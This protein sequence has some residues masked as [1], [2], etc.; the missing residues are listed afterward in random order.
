MSVSAELSGIPKG[1]MPTPPP[2]WVIRAVLAVRRFVVW[3]ADR[4][5]PPDVVVLE[6]AAGVA[7][8]A[9]IATLAKLGYAELLA[10]GPLG[11]REIAARTGCDPDA[12]LRFCHFF[13]TIGW[14][15]MTPDGV[16]S[17]TPFLRALRADN[18]MRVRSFVEYF[19]SR[20]NVD[21]IL[22]IA[23]TLRTG[24]NAFE[25][26]HGAVVWDYFDAHPDE[27]ETFAHA[28]MGLTLAD[29]PFVAKGYPFS[30]VRTVCDIGGGRG[31]LLSEI[32]LHHPHLEGVLAENPGVL[33]SAR[34]L[35]AHRGLTSRVRL[36]PCDFMTKAP[37]AFDLYLLK[38]ILHDWDDATCMRILRNIRAAMAPGA[39]LLII[40]GFIDRTRP[41]PL[42][43]PSDIQMMLVCAEGRERS[44]AELHALLAQTGF[45]PARHFA[46]A[47]LGMLE[48]IA[49]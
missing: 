2:G 23:E 5:L 37:G 8:T 32:L 42:H 34:E 14:L 9:G 22:D 33:E 40:E 1:P 30:E 16:F 4:L 13:A 25:R 11:Y 36:E 15:G 21:A 26:V 18:P 17:S 44:L 45:T 38:N 28:M 7:Y 24:K 39:R 10:G 12:T 35:L 41:D 19:A 46:L 31:T 48:A 47:T 43:A 3:V 6:R 49:S 20:S 27:R 29:A